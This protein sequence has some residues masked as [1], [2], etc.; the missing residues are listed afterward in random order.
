[1]CARGRRP[2]LSSACLLGPCR[3]CMCSAA[4]GAGVVALVLLVP[5]DTLAAALRRGRSDALPV[6]GCGRAVMR[7]RGAH[8]RRVRARAPLRRRDMG[9]KR[10]RRADRAARMAPGLS[11][12]RLS[13]S[14]NHLRQSVL[15]PD[16][17]MTERRESSR[18]SGLSGKVVAMETGNGDRTKRVI[19]DHYGGPEVLKV[20]EEDAPR[21]GPGEV[22][23]RVLAAGVSFTD[24]Q[25]AQVRTSRAP[26]S[27]RSRPAMSSSASSRSW[28]Q[29]AGGC[30]RET[31][32]A[33]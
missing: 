10:R 16:G 6:R 28:G 8:P 11:Q 3:R 24:A 14:R 30:G 26:R 2:S 21:P 9:T 20:I 13:L 17:G 25:L 33:R 31:A 27:R 23:V 5:F 29:A 18:Q 7:D 19:V 22:R 1:M 4:G 15:E 12:S 32:S